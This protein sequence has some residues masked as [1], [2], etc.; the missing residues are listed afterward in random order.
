L[1]VLIGALGGQGGGVLAEWLA[2][3]AH[4]AGYPAQVTST[5]GVAQRTGA[6]TY[7][8]E[9]FSE[10]EPVAQPVFSL[11]PCMDDVDLV[12]ALE[13]MEAARALDLGFVTGRTTVVTARERVYAIGEKIVAGDGTVDAAG[14]VDALSR[15]A[16]R[17]I[18][19][20][21]EKLAAAAGSRGNAVL[22]GAIVG[23]GVL[24]LAP[25]VCRQAIDRAGVNAKANL[26]GF[27]AGVEAATAPSAPPPRPAAA[28]MNAPPPVFRSEV[29]ALPAELH[30]L[31]GHAL[32][33]LAEYQDERY[34][35]L[36][37]KRLQAVVNADRAAGGGA[38]GFALSQE[39]ARRLAAWMRFEDVIRVAELK[40]RPGRLARIR[41]EVG[42]REDDPV[43]VA[44]FLSPRGEEMA[45][46]LP[47]ALARLIP[48]AGNRAA[49]RGLALRFPTGTPLG[50][51]ALKAIGKMKRWRP[52]TARY[53]HEQA[54]IETW[55][56][57]VVAA[58][59]S[60]D[61]A[62]ARNVAE[63]AIWARGYGDVR[64]AGDARLASLFDNFAPRLAA[65]RNG[66]AA[67]VAK[68]LADARGN[69]DGQCRPAQGR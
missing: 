51:A 8:F 43:H 28:A 7:Y 20:D 9:L 21:M 32:A 48:R 44:D 57:A 24:P 35:T 27:A 56:D 61:Y 34:A 65:D 41:A 67:D 10:R 1:T 47:P 55:L 49:T 54:A 26:A 62:L 68:A 40:T 29:D 12:A 36:F 6:T 22:F 31:A 52:R 50:F 58:A 45:G 3:A 14:M 69:P 64:S 16:K 42:A 5:P 11:F 23:S 18:A 66:L 63:L 15:A 59:G 46:L 13:P 53:A 2:E 39:T 19:L 4:L 38:R 37:L 17:V 25:D 60:G 33:Q 30:I